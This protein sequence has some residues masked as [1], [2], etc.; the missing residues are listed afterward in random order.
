MWNKSW[1]S[2]FCGFLGNFGGSPL[3][4]RADKCHLN[5]QLASCTWGMQCCYF[6][7]CSTGDQAQ[8]RGEGLQ[9]LLGRQSH[10]HRPTCAGAEPAAKNRLVGR[11]RPA[12]SSGAWRKGLFS[13]CRRCSE[14]SQTLL[15]AEG[16]FW[17]LISWPTLGWAGHE[18]HLFLLPPTSDPA[19][20]SQGVVLGLIDS[21]M[22]LSQRTFLLFSL[23]S[24]PQISCTDKKY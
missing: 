16:D 8:L 4:G 1:D 17:A 3:R 2:S 15:M 12:L 18:A 5:L 19:L 22:P 14:A 11:H 7:R 24:I 9:W 13:V 21:I 20:V 10:V 6:W 23:L